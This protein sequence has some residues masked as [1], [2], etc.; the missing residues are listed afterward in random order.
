MALSFTSGSDH[1]GTHSAAGLLSTAQAYLSPVPSFFISTVATILWARPGF[2]SVPGV[3]ASTAARL[4]CTLE[5]QAGSFNSTGGVLGSGF[6]SRVS[7]GHFT[8]VFCNRDVTFW[9]PM[10]NFLEYVLPKQH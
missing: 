4:P 3:S 6:S 7:G 9:Y 1:T 2:A 8:I 5:C 10:L